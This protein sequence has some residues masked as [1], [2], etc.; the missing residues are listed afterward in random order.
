MLRTATAA[1]LAA[2]VDA[3]QIV[4]VRIGLRAF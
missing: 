4:D 1:A 2:N 3:D